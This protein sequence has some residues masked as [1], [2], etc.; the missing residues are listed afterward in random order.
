MSFSFAFK[1]HTLTRR[2][3]MY[4]GVETVMKSSRNVSIP[5]HVICSLLLI[6]STFKLDV[7]E[8]KRQSAEQHESVTVKRRRQVS[9]AAWPSFGSGIRCHPANLDTGRHTWIMKSDLAA[10]WPLSPPWLCK[11]Q[12]GSGARGQRSATVSLPLEPWRADLPSL[13]TGVAFD[14][15]NTCCESQQS[16]M[17]CLIDS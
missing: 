15:Q 5:V 3:L 12:T 16:N 8:S 14:V 2:G 1:K 17:I 4:A 11:S 9:W 10:C 13:V 7:D 6:G